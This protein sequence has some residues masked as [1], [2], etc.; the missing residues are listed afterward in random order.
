MSDSAV[1]NP[2]TVAQAQFDRIS[3]LIGLEDSIRALLRVPMR[4]I[5]FS[6][7]VRMDDGHTLVFPGF[8][9]QHNDARG[10]SKGGVRF[11]PLGTIDTI[12]AL[13]M[14]NTWKTAAVDLPLGGSMGGVVCDPHTLST[15][16]QERISR[17]WIRQIARNLGPVLDVPEPDI[18]TGPQHMTWMMD[19]YDIIYGGRNPGAITGKPTNAGGSLGRME[20]AG[21]GL[22]YTLREALKE[23]EMN[24]A[25]TTASVQGFGKVAQHAIS[26]YQQIGGTVTSVSSWD[27]ASSEAIA[28]AKSGGVD[29]E[30]LRR[31]SDRFGG[32]DRAKAQDLGYAVLPGREWLE[33]KVDILLPAAIEN[34]ITQA[35]VERIPTTVRIVA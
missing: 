21:Y 28:F 30:E 5:H 13:A 16:E 6:I 14:W 31:I 4:E 32:I 15:R 22:V 33:Q 27:Q 19:E 11:H 9:V 2:F 7:P 24:P 8:R 35:D 3:D 1:F 20:A 12:R 29:L 23:L 17:G 26:L 25:G 10:P 18:M 34:Q